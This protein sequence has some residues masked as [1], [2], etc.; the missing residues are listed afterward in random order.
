MKRKLI[1]Y[2]N[3]LKDKDLPKCQGKFAVDDIAIRKIDNG[4]YRASWLT[5][6]RFND[7]I[8]CIKEFEGTKWS[9]K[10][11]MEVVSG[12]YFNNL[13]IPS[14]VGY[15]TMMTI[16]NV[17]SNTSLP[18]HGV[19]THYL[20]AIPGIEFMDGCSVKRFIKAELIEEARINGDHPP[21]ISESTGNWW[22]L[23]HN[24]LSE[25]LLGVMTRE[26]FDDFISLFIADKL[27]TYTDRHGQNYFFYRRA[28]S[29]LWEGVVAI[30]NE[31]VDS[32]IGYIGGKTL[33][34]TEFE[35]LLNERKRSSPLLSRI[36]LCL[37]PTS[38]VAIDCTDNPLYIT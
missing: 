11:I 27:G 28:G 16:D 25:K 20:H 29:H 14:V 38:I 36:N 7:D 23:E 17:F 3:S 1:E 33:H 22:L 19:A 12:Q 34:G 2:F 15:P 26:C 10:E 6:Y 30:D 32:Q 9:T 5:P 37:P 13:K 18:G 8:M 24:F 35:R 31:R 4:N 21:N